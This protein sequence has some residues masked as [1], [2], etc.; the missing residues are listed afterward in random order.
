MIKRII[1][2]AV[3]CLFSL[4]LPLY[5]IAG[6][7]TSVFAVS[8][9]A[10]LPP[11]VPTPTPTAVPTRVEYILPYPGMLPDH[12]LYMLKKLRDAIIEM[13]I[14]NPINKSEFYILQADKKLNM[15]ISLSAQGKQAQEKDI[16][17]QSLVART[18][19][20]TLLEETVQSG[21]KVP[22]FVLEKMMV[23]LSKHKEVLSDLKLSTDEVARLT[24]RAQALFTKSL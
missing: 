1:S 19:A 17:A 14:S 13:L 5:V 23:S 22:A 11:K 21:G 3:L 20:V 10:Q 8:T 6:T 12:P 24:T 16:L 18:Q 7:P 15:G 9:S 4:V 2:I